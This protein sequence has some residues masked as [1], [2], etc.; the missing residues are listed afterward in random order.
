MVVRGCF[1]KSNN[2]HILLLFHQPRNED[3]RTSGTTTSTRHDTDHTCFPSLIEIVSRKF[4]SH[5]ILLVPKS[6][7][8]LT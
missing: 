3:T 8:P 5:T 4:F 2:T 7:A 1:P 6:S